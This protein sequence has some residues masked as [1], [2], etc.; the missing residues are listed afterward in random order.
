MVKKISYFL[1]LFILMVVFLEAISFLAL[2][3]IY[4]TRFPETVLIAE[5]T[6]RILMQSGP[7]GKEHMPDNVIHPYLGFVYN[8]ESNSENRTKV[9]SGFPISRY[10][11]IDDK[12][13]F[14]VRSPNKVILGITGGSLAYGFSALGY[15]QLITELQKDPL[16]R[17]KEFVIVRL[18]LGGFKQPQQLM[19]LNYLL[20]LG[21][22]FDILINIDGFN[23]VG[24][25]TAENVPKKIVPYF[26]H[27]W[28]FNFLH[29]MGGEF[30][31]EF[32]QSAQ[33]FQ[34][35]GEWARFFYQRPFSKSKTLGLIWKMGDRLMTSVNTQK[36]FSFLS[37][38]P[39]LENPFNYKITGP[40][41]D[42][43]SEK[44]IYQEISD[45]WM[46]SSLL[47]HQLC[48]ANGVRYFHFLQPN[49]YLAGTR[50]FTAEEKRKAYNKNHPYKPGVEKG[51]PLLI[52]SGRA[53]RAKGVNFHDLTRV[54]ARQSQPVYSDDCCHFYPPI[55]ELLGTHIGQLM[56][57]DIHGRKSNPN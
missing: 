3:A 27:G 29:E 46:R 35:D 54:F 38:Q 56:L 47:L 1:L 11:F 55:Y 6:S 52:E 36:F 16:F 32:T 40:W 2:A 18:A 15:K 12:E 9:H 24:I 49:Q 41:R 5:Q 10:G 45:V 4:H 42:Y 43:A 25:S 13:P 50:E 37:S 21:A 28:Y 57:K 31:R 44:D 20:S 51:Y 33:L 19:T 48:E 17:D 7:K 26:P 23:E 8:Y 39:K 14:Q 30:L 34:M 22:Q 53:L